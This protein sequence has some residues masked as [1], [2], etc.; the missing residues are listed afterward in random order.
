[1]IFCAGISAADSQKTVANAQEAPKKPQVGVYVQYLARHGQDPVEYLVNLFDKYD[2]VVFMES[3]HVEQ[4]Q[5]DYLGKVIAHPKFAKLVRAVFTEVGCAGQQPLMD[6]FLSSPALDDQLLIKINR[7]NVWPLGWSYANTINFW[8]QIWQVNS[9]LSPDMK[10]WAYLT[11]QWSWDKIKTPQDYQK[12]EAALIGRDRWMADNIINAIERQNDTVNKKHKFL[13]IMNA[14]HAFGLALNRNGK[15]DNVGR[16]LKLKWPGRVGNV[17]QHYFVPVAEDTTLIHDGLWDAAFY[18]NGDK[19]AGFDLKGSPFGQDVFDFYG[20][21][22]S[23][24]N[25]YETVFDGM[26]FLGPLKDRMLSGPYPG[27]YDPAYDQQVKERCAVSNQEYMDTALL[28][29]EN[30]RPACSE[31]C[32]KTIDDAISAWKKQ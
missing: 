24:G 5:Y 7:V 8:K 32:K 21:L 16:Y 23:S 2:V 10:I 3:M 22:Y 31:S 4:G 20:N 1:M 15:G 25:T 30:A 18:L 19:P 29:Q 9:K 13:V 14:R 6:A 12:A 11:D 27:F 17:F 28:A 26:V